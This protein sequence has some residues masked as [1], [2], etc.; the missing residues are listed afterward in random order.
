MS[1]S[2]RSAK[3]NGLDERQDGGEKCDTVEQ[4]ACKLKSGDKD[5]T[6]V[7]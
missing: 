3:Q 2:S 7:T 6:V 5:T 1:R 4:S